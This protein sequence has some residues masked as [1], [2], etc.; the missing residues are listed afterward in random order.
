MKQNYVF[1]LILALS[2]V[3]PVSRAKA[4]ESPPVIL[5]EIAWAGSEKSTADEWIELANTGTE[6]I[7]ISGWKLT[8]VGTSGTS[9]DI[10]TESTIA[11]QS[12][13]LVANY[14]LGDEKTTLNISP[15]LVTTAVSI[16]NSAINISLMDTTG[17][18]IDS[19]IDPGTPNAGS[20]ATF[21]SME[22]SITDLSWIS[23]EQSINLLNEQ[24]GSPGVIGHAVPEPTVSVDIAQEAESIELTPAETPPSE[25]TSTEPDSTTQSNETQPT[26]SSLETTEELPVPIDDSTTATVIEIETEPIQESVSPIEDPVATTPIETIETPILETTSTSLPQLIITGF[27]S[28]PIT[29][30]NEWIEITN[31]GTTTIDLATFTITDAVGKATVLT[32]TLEPNATT[33]IESPLGKLNNDGDTIHILGIDG[34]VVNTIEYGTDAFAA[35]KS[36]VAMRLIGGV[37]TAIE[38]IAIIEESLAEIETTAE[39][40]TELPSSISDDANTSVTSTSTDTKDTE[41][42]EAV[43]I[44]VTTDIESIPSTTSDSA[45]GEQSDESVVATTEDTVTETTTPELIES[46]EVVEETM[47]VGDIKISSAFPSPNTGDDEWV[48]L[49]NTTESAIDISSLVLVDASSTTTALAGTV[50]A[51]ATVFITNPKGNL[52]ND[53]DSISLIDSTGTVIDA[54]EYGTESIPAPKKGETIT[55]LSESSTPYENTSSV[56]ADAET[57]TGSSSHRSASSSRQSTAQSTSVATTAVTNTPVTH[58]TTSSATS[59][60]KST[61]KT[62]STTT[63][64]IVNVDAVNSLAD[65]TSVTLEGTVVGLPGIIG[66]RSFYLDGLEVYQSQG[67]LAAVSIGDHVRITGSVSVLSD[68]SRVNIKEGGVI[69]LG[70]TEPIVHDYADGLSYGTLVRVSGTVNARDGNA[71]ILKTENDESMTVTLGNGVTISWENLAGKNVTIVGILKKNTEKTSIVLR[72]AEDITVM[73]AATDISATATMAATTTSIQIPWLGITAAL[74]VTAGL[75]TWFW[76]YR[77]QSSLTK[78]TLHPTKV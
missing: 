55:F 33:T 62:S 5:S 52:N 70:T 61:A 59:V 66:K 32:G 16:P 4:A 45:S 15:N 44:E 21:T 75:G 63:P 71:I 29:G 47:H 10:P 58:S 46:A 25:T 41:I 48:A 1:G 13:Y 54:V 64:K 36:N 77:P 9:I 24:L 72:S 69:V 68:H 51:G 3:S 42:V 67:D 38:P 18:V 35:P 78:L 31:I 73:N 57:A 39:A 14:K 30:T 37:W 49:T 40:S 76:R 8:G 6:T 19:C 7:D 20:S 26:T 56:L 17:L 34:A 23:A 65:E 22:R 53:G 50:D 11:A 74:L 27:L 12:T 2:I 43:T 28:A 60:K